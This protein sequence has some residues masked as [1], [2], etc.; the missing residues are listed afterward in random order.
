M[1]DVSR[2]LILRAIANVA[3]A[4]TIVSRS[5]QYAYATGMIEMAYAES[6]ISG[7]EHDDFR[8]QLQQIELDSREVARA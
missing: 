6:C 4:T 8:R 5:I 7:A 2:R 3:S 1:S